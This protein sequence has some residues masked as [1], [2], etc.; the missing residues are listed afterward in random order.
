MNQAVVVSIPKY[1]IIKGKILTSLKWV[2]FSAVILVLY[3]PILYII[4]QAFNNSR[5][6]QNFGGFTLKWF[7][8][9]FQTDTLMSAIYTTVSIAFFAT[10]VSIVIGTLAAIGINAL[11][12][13]KRKRMIMLNNIPILNADIVTGVFLR[14]T[15]IFLSMLL[16]TVI[17]LGY[18]TLLVAHIFFCIPYVVL[19]IL[20]KLNEIDDN[21]F[22][23]AMDLGCNPVD[24]LWKVIIPSIKSGIIAGG[25][26]AFTMSI[27]DFV[28]SYMTTAP[29]LQNFSIWLYSIKNPFTN[30]AMQLASAYN[31]IISLGTIIILV[32]Y[33]I[34]KSK[35]KGLKK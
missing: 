10:M 30:N 3:L 5:T 12:K 29:G 17:A 15:F 35:K 13:K 7:A 27:D 23:A 19:S 2:F 9:M 32:V 34:L 20:P 8:Q 31:T 33:N 6:G 14:V 11:D 28:I 25:L 16:P 22:D 21:L 18:N 4:M 1:K 24:A 26:I